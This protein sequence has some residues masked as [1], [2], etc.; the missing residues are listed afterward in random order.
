MK[1]HVIERRR[2]K[3][4]P[5]WSVIRYKPVADGSIF[6]SAASYKFATTNNVSIG[7]LQFETPAYY[8]IATPLECHM[9]I[10]GNKKGMT[11]HGTVVRIEAVRKPWLFNT[12]IAFQHI[13]SEQQ[14]NLEH[15]ITYYSSC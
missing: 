4:V 5:F 12:A 11:L 10:P 1:I 3:R 14:K 13:S 15:Y 8:S 6:D 7:G 9:V 2:H